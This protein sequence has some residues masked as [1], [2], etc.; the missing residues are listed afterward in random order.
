MPLAIA[1]LQSIHHIGATVIFSKFKSDHLM[2][3]HEI[4]W[5]L[6]MYLRL[7][8]QGSLLPMRPGKSWSQ[9]VSLVSAPTILP[10]VLVLLD[11]F[12][13]LEHARSLHTPQC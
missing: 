1:P 5:W 7:K 10:S 13:L 9:P 6:L 2:P 12:Q 11:F 8:S 3:L 4:L